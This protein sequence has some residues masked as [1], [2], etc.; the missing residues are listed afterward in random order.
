MCVIACVSVHHRD[1]EDLL[2]DKDLG[3]FLIRL[4]D[5]AIGFILS[6]KYRV[7]HSAHCWMSF[8]FFASL[9]WPLLTQCVSSPGVTTGV[10]I[11]S[12]LRTRTDTLS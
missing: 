12:L 2:R 4:S 11:L 8:A 5:K 10:A 1:T 7:V 3:S 6:Y 9:N